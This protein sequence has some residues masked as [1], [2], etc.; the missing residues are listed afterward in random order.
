MVAPVASLATLDPQALIAER[1]ESREWQQ[2]NQIERAMAEGPQPEC[3]LRHLFTPV[4]GYP[5]LKLYSREIT[6]PAGILLTS[7]IHLFEHPF[8]ISQGVCSVWSDETGWITYRAPFRGVTSPATRRLLYIHE[9]T[10]WTTF[11]VTK[12]TDPDLAVDEISISPF[13]FGHL[14]DLAP[15]KRAAIEANRRTKPQLT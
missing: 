12:H 10:I 14:A 15:E 2:L 1:K 8:I 9:L 13:E 4:P 5:D 6:M 3:P 11:H 7:F